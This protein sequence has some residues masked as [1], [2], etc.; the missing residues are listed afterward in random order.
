MKPRWLRWA[1]LVLF[2]PL[3]LVGFLF[4]GFALVL[5]VIVMN[6]VELVHAVVTDEPFRAWGFD[7]VMNP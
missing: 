1:L 7:D 5:G 4:F 6:I 3:L 2:S